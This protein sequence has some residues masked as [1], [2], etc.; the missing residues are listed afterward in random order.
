[1]VLVRPPSGSSPSRYQVLGRLAGGGMAEILLG[2]MTTGTGITK[3]VVLKRVLSEYGNDPEYLQMFLDEARLSFTLA[4]PNIAQ[5]Y[6]F[7]EIDG[8]YYLAM[9]YVHGENTHHLLVRSAKHRKPVPLDIVATIVVGAAGGL[10]HA[11]TRT[12]SDRRPLGIVHRD[13]S[14]A[15]IMLSFEGSVKIVDFG[16]AKATSQ[17]GQRS[18]H[19]TVGSTKGKVGY[20]SPEQI[21]SPGKVDR[22]SDIFTLGIVMWELLTCKRL[23]KRATDLESMEATCNHMAPPPS[24]LRDGVPPSFDAVVARALQKDPDARFATAGE[25]LVA[26]EKAAVSAGLV[27]STFNL[28]SFITELFGE[29]PEPWIELS[30][31]DRRGHGD[32]V[33]DLHSPDVTRPGTPVMLTEP[34]SPP[35]A[36][37]LSA[38]VSTNDATEVESAAF[39]GTDQVSALLPFDA[40]EV[41][42]ADDERWLPLAQEA[43]VATADHIVA[44]FTGANPVVASPPAAVA[45]APAVAP[46]VAAASITRDLKVPDADDYTIADHVVTDHVAADLADAEPELDERTIDLAAPNGVLTVAPALGRMGHTPA[47]R[48]VVPARY[49]RGRGTWLAVA[50][51][52]VV[53]AGL[54]VW[55]ALQQG[56]ATV[57]NVVE[58]VPEGSALDAM[59]SPSGDAIVAVAVVLDAAPNDARAAQ[60]AAA[61]LDAGLPTSDAAPLMV[62]APKQMSAQLLRACAKAAAGN[63]LACAMAACELHDR[64]ALRRY[65][66]SSDVLREVTKTATCARLL[67]KSEKRRP[68]KNASNGSS[69]T[70]VDCD[71]EPLKCQF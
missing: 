40:G 25:M 56:K 33:T 58:P 43:S 31:V 8:A 54:G 6:D 68:P 38:W 49:Q 66:R 11:H 17:Q 19:T 9:E 1:M 39:L 37:L 44:K 59:P 15:N 18:V 46:A 4:H 24:R 12:T 5:V 29:T 62:V 35:A 52:L 3:H 61:W 28:G 2:K 14:P 42:D 64:A 69:D 10:H 55:F 7:T 60:P 71:K 20:M 21:R 41:A 51:L 70:G 50:L 23:Y 48:V 30:T 53:A 65:T 63:E 16:V 34:A 47:V 27:L 22:R 45:V 32:P 67:K 13:V 57:A 26:V 36:A